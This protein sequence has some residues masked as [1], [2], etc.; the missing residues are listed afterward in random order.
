MEILRRRRNRNKEGAMFGQENNAYTVAIVGSGF[1]GTLVAT[2]LLLNAGV[3]RL[4]VVLFERAASRFARGLAYG[5]RCF[6][7]LLNVP[8]EKMSAFIEDQQHFLR[9]AERHALNVQEDSFVPRLVYGAYLSDVLDEAEV[10]A[11]DG[12]YLVLH[13]TRLRPAT[14]E[15]S[16]DQT[17]ARARLHPPRSTGT[18]PRHCG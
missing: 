15:R 4:R 16:I 11:P 10:N 8:A 3:Q 5:T 1:S 2:Q 14:H 6:A 17:S 12:S 13:W 18:R 7:H 9:W